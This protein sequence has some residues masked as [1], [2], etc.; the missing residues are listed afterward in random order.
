MRLFEVMKKMNEFF[1]RIEDGK[2]SLSDWIPKNWKQVGDVL[3]KTLIVIV[4]IPILS[5]IVYMLLYFWFS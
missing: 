3:K 5:V 4:G 1:D 2:P